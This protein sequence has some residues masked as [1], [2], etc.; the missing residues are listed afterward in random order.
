[1]K[2]L[3]IILVL[4]LVPKVH[5]DAA[6]DA[7]SHATDAAMK[8]SGLQKMLDDYSQKQLKNVPK[9][10]QLVVGNTALIVKI[11]QDHKIS[12]TWEFQ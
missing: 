8:Q 3:I 6:S 2:V 12:H 5:A 4:F 11:I 9:E 7:M 1:M 10:L